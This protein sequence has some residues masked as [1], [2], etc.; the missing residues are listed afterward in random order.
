MAAAVMV[1]VKEEAGKVVEERVEGVRA[2]VAAVRVKVAATGTAA[3]AMVKVAHWTADRTSVAPQ[4]GTCSESSGG[5]GS[6]DVARVQAMML[7]K[8]VQGWTK[9]TRRRSL[10]LCER[11][12]PK[13]LLEP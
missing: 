5:G 1:V 2:K 3:A 7:P 12:L 10:V 13:K 8:T 9:E 6:W 4:P 11:R